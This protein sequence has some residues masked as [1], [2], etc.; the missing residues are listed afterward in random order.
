L[1]AQDIPAWGYRFYPWVSAATTIESDTLLISEESMENSFFHLEFNQN[2]QIVSIWDKLSD[3]EVLAPG[4]KGNLLTVFDDRPGDGEAWVIDPYYQDKPIVIEQLLEKVVE[5]TGPLRIVLRL[6]W[7]FAETTI[8]QR[9]TMYRTNPRIDFRTELNWQQHQ[10]ILKVAF[11][12]NVRATQATYEIQ[13]GNIQRPTHKNTSFDQAHYENPAQKWADL[14]EGDYGVALLNDSKYGYDI[15]GHVLRLTLHRSPIEPDPQADQG[16]HQFTYSLLP[17]QGTWRNSVI[18]R[19]AYALNT[20]EHWAV[21]PSNPAGSL[22]GSLSWCQVDSDH[23]ILETLK[24]AEDEPAWILRLYE[25]KQY[26]NDNV[27]LRFWHPVKKVVVV[28]L[29]E[30]DLQPLKTINDSVSISMRPYEIKTL[31][32]WFAD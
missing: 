21:V 30:R 5:E 11:P 7:A 15:H 3:C 20:P 13:F 19:E 12:V 18:A 16:L 28:D 32:V 31:K 2:G 14:S 24:Q 27:Q 6:V 22:P 25:Y 9:V 8:T 1:E 4:E 10:M 23:V 26:R 17:H 29:L